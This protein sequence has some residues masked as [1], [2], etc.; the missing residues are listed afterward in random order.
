MKR[1]RPPLFAE[2]IRNISN[3]CLL[4][5]PVTGVQIFPYCNCYNNCYTRFCCYFVFVSPCLQPIT[6]RGTVRFAPSR[7]DQTGGRLLYIYRHHGRKP[8]NFSLSGY[9]HGSSINPPRYNPHFMT[10]VAPRLFTSSLPTVCS[11]QSSG[12]WA[13]SAVCH[14]ARR[15]PRLCRAGS[16]YRQCTTRHSTARYVRTR[17]A[18]CCEGDGNTRHQYTSKNTG[19]SVNYSSTDVPRTSYDTHTPGT[20]MFPYVCMRFFLSFA[21]KHTYDFGTN[22]YRKVYS[23]GLPGWVQ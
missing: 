7:A 18:A 23:D 6:R 3:Y 5:V 22:T 4:F 12:R 10:P 8:R 16:Y 14:T 11:R 1:Y 17:G 15:A 9:I 2:K 19:W 20:L 13:R 21:Y